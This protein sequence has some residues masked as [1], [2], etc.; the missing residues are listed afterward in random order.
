MKSQIYVS[1]KFTPGTRTS[2]Q[3]PRH[4]RVVKSAFPSERNFTQ[5]DRAFQSPRQQATM[6]QVELD[7]SNR[8]RLSSILR[9]AAICSAVNV[10]PQ[11]SLNS[12]YPCF[13]HVRCLV[14]FCADL[15]GPRCGNNMRVPETAGMFRNSYRY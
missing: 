15:P 11:K 3:D 8:G 14:Q 9:P 7:A 6:A 2:L 5:L 13:L 10:R 1:S 12:N 4:T